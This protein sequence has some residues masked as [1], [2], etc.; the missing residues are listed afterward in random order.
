MYSQ[1]LNQSI[2]DLPEPRPE[3]ATKAD[4]LALFTIEEETSQQGAFCFEDFD[5]QYLQD[6]TKRYKEEGINIQ[7]R[8]KYIGPKKKKEITNKEIAIMY[9]KATM[10]TKKK[11][12]QSRIKK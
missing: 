9:K 8:P 3:P 2:Y 12:S 1:V 4:M 11:R 10:T 5:Q 7:F 6:V